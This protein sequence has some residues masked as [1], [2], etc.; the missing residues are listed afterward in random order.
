V[1]LAEP[2]R[3]VVVRYTHEQRSR[4]EALIGLPAH[5][6]LETLR[7][8]DGAP[9]RIPADGLLLSSALAE[10][11]HAGVGD[12]V[13]VDVLEGRRRHIELPVAAVFDTY[14]GS[15]AYMDL[16][17]LTRA[18]GEPAT[19]NVV[20]LRIDPSLREAF[21]ARLKSIPVIGGATVKA[22]AVEMFHRTMGETML[23]YVSF[24]VFFS[25]TLAIGVVYN[26]L[27]IA[28]SERGRELATLRVLG[29]RTGEISYILLG[30]AAMLVLLAL[31]IGALLG[32]ALASLMAASFATELFRVP[33]V[34]ETDTYAYAMLVALGAAAVSGALVQRRVRGLDLVAVLKTR[35]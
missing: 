5:G 18:I 11:L 15:T 21:F 32:W 9:V 23:V 33:V 28:L 26:N 1:L 30:E 16:A 4:R 13:S 2:R 19:A 29:F 22:A 27:R 7:T 8:V 10:V 6:Q 24:Y 31:P 25:C 3:S 20:L 12:M 17:A 34:I 14:I 35:D